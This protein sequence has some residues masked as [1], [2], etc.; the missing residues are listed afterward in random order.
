MVEFRE[1]TTSNGSDLTLLQRFYSECLIPAFPDPDERDSLETIEEYLRQEQCGA[2]AAKRYH[3]IVA[4]NRD[5][6]VAGSVSN[7]L[8]EPNA[9]VIE[10][11]LVDPAQRRTG[12]ATRLREFTERTLAADAQ[13]SG[14]PIGWV[15]GEIDDPF[16]T[17]RS[18]AGFDPFS[19]AWIWHRWGYRMLD[20]PYIQPALSGEQSAV[21]TL[22][23]MAKTYAPEFARSIPAHH[24][25]TLLREYLRWGMGIATPDEDPAFTAMSNYLGGADNSVALVALSDYIG[26]DDPVAPLRIHE[27]TGRD[28]PELQAAID[29]YT[30][31]FTD[32]ATAIPAGEFRLAFNPGG[33]ADQPGCHYHLWSIQRPEVRPARAWHRF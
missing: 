4:A 6:P 2:L 12:L 17:P 15:V 21:E 33:L 25:L 18:P 7:Y 13:R 28:D 3:V 32:P 5:V 10:F 1:I 20:F 11:L 19:R 29:V 8:S 26:S 31:V 9:G 16:R 22:L 24:V 30:A 14:H 27:I 23:L